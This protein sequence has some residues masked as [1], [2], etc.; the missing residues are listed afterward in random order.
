V[1]TGTTGLHCLP[2]TGTKHGGHREQ[3]PITKEGAGRGDR[4]PSEP[5]LAPEQVQ[6]AQPLDRLLEAARGWTDVV[7]RDIG[8]VDSDASVSASNQ[9]GGDDT[10]MARHPL[11]CKDSF[12]R[13]H[14]VNYEEIDKT[15]L[16]VINTMGFHNVAAKPSDRWHCSQA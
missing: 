12:I 16:E 14:G 6:R 11:P 15:S 5:S 7:M 3:C 13:K 4:Q 2:L 10:T 9:Y 8:A 1:A